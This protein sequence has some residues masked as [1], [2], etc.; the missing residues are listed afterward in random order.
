MCCCPSAPSI[1]W[2]VVMGGVPVHSPGRHSLTFLFCSPSNIII[3]FVWSLLAHSLLFPFPCVVNLQG[4]CYIVPSHYRSFLIIDIHWYLCIYMLLL[5]HCNHLCSLI[6]C[7]VFTTAVWTF[8]PH[9]HILILY[10]HPFVTCCLEYGGGGGT[11][12][13]PS[14]IITLLVTFTRPPHLSYPLWWQSLNRRPFRA[15]CFRLQSFVVPCCPQWPHI[16]IYSHSPGINQYLVSEYVVTGPRP[17]LHSLTFDLVSH[18][19]PHCY[20]LCCWCSCW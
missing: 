13:F 1:W 15:L 20:Y 6:C 8:F 11:P 3:Y 5:L 10:I 12:H 19:A 18:I 16:V 7:D 4:I 17:L 9:T 14:F 2:V